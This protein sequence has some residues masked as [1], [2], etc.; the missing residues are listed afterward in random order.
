MRLSVGEALLSIIVAVATIAVIVGVSVVVFLNPVWVGFEQERSG[1][2]ALTGYS[3]D[4]VHAVTGGVLSDLV[5]GPHR[6]SPRSVAGAAVFDD[7]ER[8]H[9][10]D[11]RSVFIGFGAP[12]PDRRA[13]TCRRPGSPRA[14]APWFR[15]ADRR[16][17][18][19]PGRRSSS[20]ERSSRSSRSTRPSRR[21]TSCSSPAGPTP[22]TRCPTASSNC[23]RS[24]SGRRP[25][26]RSASSSSSSR[27]SWP[28][29]AFAGGDR[30]VSEPLLSVEDARERVLA[31]LDAPLPVETHTPE[32]ALGQVLA[33]AVTATTDLPPW[34]NSAMDGYAIRAADVAAATE[35]APVTL[36]VVGEVPAGGI[37]PH[38]R[39]SRDR[40]PHRDRC[41]RSRPVPT[42]SCRSSRPP[43]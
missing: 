14:G 31:A 18:P 10:Q 30:G 23:S 37:A 4:D 12:R 35:T 42:P 38:G 27:A 28:G 1:A 43:R 41:T 25:R 29:S 17:G 19:G 6:P 7:R 36:R 16:W 11:V 24:S 20:S 32:N 39:G 15:R 9:L 26:W 2:P 3:T 34:D 5:I 8:S 33:V 40:H 21:S 13:R 22:S